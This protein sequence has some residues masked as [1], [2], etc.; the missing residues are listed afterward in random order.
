VLLDSKPDIKI[1]IEDTLILFV[2]RMFN[3]KEAQYLL[4]TLPGPCPKI[5][6]YGRKSNMDSNLHDDTGGGGCVF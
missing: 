5:S 3:Y 2:T 1:K 4:S 6:M